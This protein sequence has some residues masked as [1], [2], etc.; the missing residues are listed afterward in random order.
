MSW[1]RSE[2]GA[3]LVE[4]ALI[5]PLLVLLLF[6]IID[7]ARYF[8]AASSVNSA[9]RESA[10]FGSIV[11][12]DDANPNYAN[13]A[14][15]VG[16]GL[17]FRDSLTDA[18]Y[19][20]DY[21]NDDA[22]TNQVADCDDTDATYPNPS[23]YSFASGDRVRVTVTESFTFITPAVGS[24]VNPRTITSTDVRTMLSP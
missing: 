22:L 13:C 14:G 10:R 19:S 6:G 23:S 8:Y 3:T 2:D 11:G 5:M 17:R 21:F 1:Q 24:A 12:P 4:F 9:A 20:I 7:F 16:E 15:I 18:N